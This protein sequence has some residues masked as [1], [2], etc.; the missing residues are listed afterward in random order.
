M[1]QAD[2][3]GYFVAAW[4]CAPS[5]FPQFANS[6]NRLKIDF[7][8]DFVRASIL[9]IPAIQH[10]QSTSNRNPASIVI[11]NVL[12]R[13]GTVADRHDR[14]APSNTSK[15]SRRRSSLMSCASFSVFA[16]GRYAL[17]EI[18]ATR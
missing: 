18:D 10:R 13:V 15:S 4:R 11:A 9:T 1:K 2:S 6:S 3:F 16:A 7:S 17:H 8:F 12:E 5:A 14:W